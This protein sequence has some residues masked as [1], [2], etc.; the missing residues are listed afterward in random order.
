MRARAFIDT[1]IFVYIQ[2]TDDP[3]KREISTKIVD[4]YECVASTQVLNEFCNIFT[5]KYPVPI[6]DLEHI[7]NAII[8]TCDISLIST[9]TIKKSFNLHKQYRYSYYLRLMIASALENNC[10]YLFTEDL[11]DGQLID[12]RLEIV[13]IFKHANELL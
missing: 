12:G 9:K 6:A 8:N 13:D 7:I 4:N 1:N 11:Q 5:R 2:R 10:E 3:A